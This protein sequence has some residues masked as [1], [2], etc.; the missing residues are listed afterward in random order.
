MTHIYIYIYT[1]HAHGRAAAHHL[2]HGTHAWGNAGAGNKKGGLVNLRCIFCINLP[3]I[4]IWFLVWDSGLQL[5][6]EIDGEF[7][8]L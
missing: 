7:R 1:A 4:K 3:F 8:K 5:V 2:H 6:H